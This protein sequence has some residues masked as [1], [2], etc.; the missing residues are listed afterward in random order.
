MGDW[1]SRPVA[2]VI[3]ELDSRPQ[4]LSEREAAQRL[5]RRGPNQLDSPAGPGM[6]VR[7]LGQLRDPMI[8]VLL[9]AALLSLAASGGRTGWTG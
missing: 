4:G 3:K 9:A 1:H 8:L 6:L 7:I 2:Q 5:E